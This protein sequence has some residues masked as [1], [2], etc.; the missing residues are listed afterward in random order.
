[1]C[2]TPGSKNQGWLTSQDG[3]N[4]QRWIFEGGL[5]RQSFLYI[6]ERALD[7]D[8]YL[9][10]GMCSFR[11][12]PEGLPQRP[13]HLAVELED[14][15]AKPILGHDIALYWRVFRT[16][17]LASEGQHGRLLDGLHA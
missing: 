6:A 14:A 7:A 10:N 8:A 12:G 2:S 4:E 5:A 16:L 3:I 13:L 15:L 11:S 17:G 9:I 1:M